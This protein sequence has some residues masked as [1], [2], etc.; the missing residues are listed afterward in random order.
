MIDQKTD[1]IVVGTRFKMSKLGAAR[2]P[3]LADRAGI[4]IGVSSRTTGIT[5]L[6]D[7]TRRPTYLHRDYIS[8]LGSGIAA[9]TGAIGP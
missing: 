8:G 6:F 5:V 2:C 9:P 7:G 4:V 1:R 3:E